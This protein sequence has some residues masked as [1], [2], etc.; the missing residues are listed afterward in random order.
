M[1]KALRQSLLLRNLVSVKSQNAN[2]RFMAVNTVHSPTE[3]HP[4]PVTRYEIR[5]VRDQYMVTLLKLL[6]SCSCPSSLLC[7][8][9]CQRIPTLLTFILYSP[10]TCLHFFNTR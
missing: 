8:H 7:P 3:P 2:A 9:S 4:P 10:S 5:E 1:S 6:G